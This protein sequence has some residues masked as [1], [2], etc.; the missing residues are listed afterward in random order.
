MSSDRKTNAEF[1]G[2]ELEKEREKDIEDGLYFSPP[3]P[4]I[5]F[6]IGLNFAA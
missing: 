4:Q 6:I 1:G 5:F 3:M 2:Q